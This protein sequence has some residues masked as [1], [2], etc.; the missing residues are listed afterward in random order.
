MWAKVWC[1][2]FSATEL[3]AKLWALF[4]NM[5]IGTSVT[6]NNNNN[7]STRYCF[8]K[9]FIIFY[10]LKSFFNSNFIFYDIWDFIMNFYFMKFKIFFIELIFTKIKILL[11]ILYFMKFIIIVFYLFLYSY[12][13]FIFKIWFYFCHFGSYFPY[14]KFFSINCKLWRRNNKFL[15]KF[16]F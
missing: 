14:L 9:E 15:V 13:Y 12:K 4:S 1:K 5:K 10:I 2:L 3:L 16:F 7:K 6:S 11:E 8:N